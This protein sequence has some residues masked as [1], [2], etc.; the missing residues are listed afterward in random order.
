MIYF[1]YN[2]TPM[3]LLKNFKIFYEICSKNKQFRKIIYKKLKE[4]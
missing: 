3:E 2:K 1:Q 4:V